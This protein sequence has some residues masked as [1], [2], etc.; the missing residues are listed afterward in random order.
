MKCVQCAYLGV[1][2]V[3]TNKYLVTAAVGGRLTFSLKSSFDGDVTRLVVVLQSE[4]EIVAV[5]KQV[6]DH[7]P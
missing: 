7:R 2:L 4:Q 1:V 3:E 6:I 5:S